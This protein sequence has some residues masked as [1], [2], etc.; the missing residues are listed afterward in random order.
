MAIRPIFVLSLP[1]SGSTLVQRVL[2]RDPAVSTATEPWVLL[3]QL[4][5]LR[6]RGAVAEYGHGPAARAIGDFAR[7]LQGGEAGYL[8]EVRRFAIGVYERASAPGSTYFLDKTPRYHLVA[9]EL[10]RVFPEGRF[11]FLWRNPLAVVASIIRTWARGS[12]TFGRWQ[13]DLHEGLA[14]LVEAYRWH[15]ADACA[16][17]YEDLVADGGRAWGRM[18]AH[19]DLTFDPRMLRS[20]PPPPAGGRMGD[21]ATGDADT[22]L[23]AT[24]VEQWRRTFN[25]PLRKRWAAGYLDWIGEGRLATM[26]YELSD[27]RR[28]LDAIPSTP[29]RLASDLARSAYGRIQAARRKR[30]FRTLSGPGRW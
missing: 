16:V 28:E 20:L 8:E 22:E 4:Y 29:R 12:W 25:N 19:L 13:I 9:E 21:R 30:F 2:A 27:L 15:G 11:V 24:S 14:N 17:R 7:S 5:A 3:P 1:R 26:G 10:F 23:D 6:D 18:F